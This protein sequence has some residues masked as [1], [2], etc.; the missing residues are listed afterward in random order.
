MRQPIEDGCHLAAIE[1]RRGDQDPD[2]CE[3]QPLCDRIGAERGEQR[4]EDA[5]RFQRSERR[6]VE[7]GNATGKRCHAG[8][9]IETP[10]SH[11]AFDVLSARD[12]G[13]QQA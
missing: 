7:I 2:P 1:Q 6:D 5:M 8:A 3:V 13:Q 10:A 12:E 4:S 9:G 11:R